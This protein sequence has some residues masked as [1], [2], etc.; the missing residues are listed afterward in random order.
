MSVNQQRAHP[1]PIDI[2]T[3]YTDGSSLFCVMGWTRL[4][5]ILEDCKT[6]KTVWRPFGKFEEM[7][8]IYPYAGNQHS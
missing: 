5:I 3:Y 7:E 6:E 1:N 8:V 4:G 2:G